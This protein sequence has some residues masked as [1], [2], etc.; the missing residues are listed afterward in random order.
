MFEQAD[1]A[2]ALREVL[3]RPEDSTSLTAGALA[4]AR[5]GG[6][7]PDGAAVERALD[8][9]AGTLALAVGVAAHP[10]FLLAGVARALFDQ[11][12]WTTAKAGAERAED[13]FIDEAVAARRAAPHLLALIVAE[14]AERAALPIHPVAAPGAAL[15]R[16][17]GWGK[18]AFLDLARRGRPLTPDECR[19][20]AVAACGGRLEFSEGWLRA[21]VREQSLARVATG[22][23]AFHW[24]IGAYDLALEAIDLLLAIRPEDPRE[25][26]DRGRLLFLQGRLREAIGAFET[27]L[28]RNPHGQDADAVRM[29]LLEA[30]TTLSS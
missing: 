6:R 18:A 17:D 11:L 4:I 12:G 1:A 3:S 13:F 25:V 24:R 9:L 28:S 23:K 16:A 27:Y 5:L 19:A 8:E 20:L 10:R 21:A 26:R 22:L 7:L 2:S 30:R 29:L 15:L 14:A